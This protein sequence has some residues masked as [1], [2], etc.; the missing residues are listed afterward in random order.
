MNNVRFGN[1]TNGSEFRS[2][3]HA[4]FDPYHLQLRLVVG[5][6]NATQN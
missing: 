5:L 6:T 2:E 4:L 1:V 3:G